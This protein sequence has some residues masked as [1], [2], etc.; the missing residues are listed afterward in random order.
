[1]AW[2]GRRVCKPSL[3]KAEQTV[4]ITASFGWRTVKA[5]R[6]ATSRN[7]TPHEGRVVFAG[8]NRSLSPTSPNATQLSYM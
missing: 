3:L 1:M 6:Y 7:G 2:Q 8:S 4:P 5:R